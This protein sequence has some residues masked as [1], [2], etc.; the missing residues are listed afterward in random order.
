M[1]IKASVG[2]RMANHGRAN[3]LSVGEDVGQQEISY[4]A[5]GHVRWHKGFREQSGGSFSYSCPDH[6]AQPFLGV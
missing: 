5:E 4:T 3:M 2:V 6:M 1:P